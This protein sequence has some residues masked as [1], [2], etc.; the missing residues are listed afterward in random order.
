M[1]QWKIEGMFGIPTVL[2]V[3]GELSKMGR[4]FID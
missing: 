2:S 4:P 3:C 1:A